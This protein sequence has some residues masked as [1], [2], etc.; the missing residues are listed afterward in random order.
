MEIAHQG[1]RA[2]ARVEA[3]A[4]ARDL[5]SRF[6]A[7]HGD[8][9]QL[10]ACPRQHFDLPRGRLRIGGIGVGHRL[11]HDR[12]AAADE[13]LA[14]RDRPGRSALHFKVRRATSTRVCGRRS[15][16]LPS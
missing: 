1:D 11:H 10:G 15:T 4:D 9:Y 16:G 13:H 2:A 3:L 6:R 12:R 7:V 8:A 14:H 5:R